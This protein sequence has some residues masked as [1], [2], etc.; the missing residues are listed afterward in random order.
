MNWASLQDVAD[1][2]VLHLRTIGRSTGLA[3]EIEI[4]FVVCC[5]RFYL[6]AETGDVRND[7]NREKTIGDPTVASGEYGSLWNE[8]ETAGA[9]GADKTVDLTSCAAWGSQLSCVALRRAE[10]RFGN[11]DKLYTLAEQERAYNTFYDSFFGSWRF[12]AP[13]RQVRLGIDVKF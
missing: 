1:K 13:A 8:A 2:Q 10:A 5:E 7:R 6:F 11:G 4:W 9:L 12:F 3:R